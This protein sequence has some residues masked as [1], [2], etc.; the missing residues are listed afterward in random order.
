MS[1]VYEALTLDACLNYIQRHKLRGA[2]VDR[3]LF[4]GRYFVLNP[5]R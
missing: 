2:I 3:C 1:Q 4:S 5:D